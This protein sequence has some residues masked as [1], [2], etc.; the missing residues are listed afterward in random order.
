MGK[1]LTI[2]IKTEGKHKATFS[3]IFVLLEGQLLAKA[4]IPDEKVTVLAKLNLLEE[5]TTEAIKVV[6]SHIPAIVSD[7][8]NSKY[9]QF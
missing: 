5:I 7:C 1:Q 6:Y 2:I 8:D 4:F 3:K 9:S